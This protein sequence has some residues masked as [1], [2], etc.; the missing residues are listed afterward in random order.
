ML[1]FLSVA[2]PLCYI[3]VILRADNTSK[4]MEEH[5]QWT[6]G[7]KTHFIQ[8]ILILYAEDGFN[9]IFIALYFWKPVSLYI[10]YLL[11]VL[12]AV[13]VYFEQ[14]SYDYLK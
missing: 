2:L 7:K 10:M 11:F 12:T 1:S 8:Y 5:T 3:L 6:R 13:T 4:R 9:F 14:S